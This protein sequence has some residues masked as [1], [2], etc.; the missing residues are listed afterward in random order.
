MVVLSC[1]NMRATQAVVVKVLKELLQS[2][3][4]VELVVTRLLSRLRLVF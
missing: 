2:V 4:V 1:L 3:L